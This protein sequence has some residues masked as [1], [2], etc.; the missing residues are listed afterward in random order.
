LCLTKKID[1]ILNIKLGKEKWPGEYPTKLRECLKE[2]QYSSPKSQIGNKTGMFRFY[3]G[4]S[5]DALVACG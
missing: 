2:V 4:S 1:I 5:Q 3:N